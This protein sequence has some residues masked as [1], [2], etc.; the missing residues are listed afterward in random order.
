MIKQM[1]GEFQESIVKDVAGAKSHHQ[2]ILVTVKWSISC[3]NFHNEQPIEQENRQAIAG[4]YARDGENSGREVK[5][6]F[7]IHIVSP[8]CFLLGQSIC[9]IA[10]CIYCFALC[11]KKWIYHNLEYSIKEHGYWSSHVNFVKIS[12]PIV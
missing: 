6:G 2:S 8:F 7:S 9:E 5:R 1:V 12:C 3:M 11:L 4:A 10:Y